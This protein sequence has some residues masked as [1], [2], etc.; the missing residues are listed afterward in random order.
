MQSFLISIFALVSVFCK[1][2][3]SCENYVHKCYTEKVSAAHEF[4][5]DVRRKHKAVALHGCLKRGGYIK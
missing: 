2:D 1:G 5:K 4:G 3:K